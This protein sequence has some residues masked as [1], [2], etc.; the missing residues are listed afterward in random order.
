MFLGSAKVGSNMIARGQLI[1]SEAEDYFEAHP[2]P[3]FF[4]TS[5]GQYYTG[6]FMQGGPRFTNRESKLFDGNVSLE[7][8]TKWFDWDIAARLRREQG[9]A[10]TTAA[11]TTRTSGT[12]RSRRA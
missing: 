3:D 7:G 5:T 10:T 4:V 2:V 8:T 1:Y 12:R 6:R 11:T 9:H